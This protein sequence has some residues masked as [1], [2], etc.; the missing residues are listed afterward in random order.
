[1][2]SF[3]KKLIPNDYDNR[4]MELRKV[5]EDCDIFDRCDPFPIWDENHRGELE[6]KIIDN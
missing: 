1:M 6:K 2:W 4:T 5:V 3:L